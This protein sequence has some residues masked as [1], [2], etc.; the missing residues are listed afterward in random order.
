V[1]WDSKD[2][3]SGPIPLWHQVA[4]RLRAAI[5]RGEFREGDALPSEAVLNRRFG[6]SRT[7]ARAALDALENER[8]VIRQ[9]GR[10][11]IVLPPPADV[12]LNLLASF[13]E[14][15]RSR[16]L[17]PSYRTESIRQV[18]ASAEVAAGLAVDRDTWVTRIER[19]LCASGRPL[20]FSIAWLSPTVLNGVKPPTRDY[21]DSGS[22][23][24]WLER[25]CG[26]RIAAGTQ[27]I[28]AGA[29]DDRIAS[30]LAVP[31]AS[32]ILIARRSSQT[33]DNLK[34]EYVVNHYRAD[35]YRFCVELVRP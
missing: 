26:A 7:T 30:W 20:A 12:P 31:T 11:S 22:L 25:E 19:L 18:K 24:A 34:V 15:M 13:E 35:L 2:L 4:E 21:L 10:G 33:M 9:S 16:G 1:T 27:Y 28:E 14:D 6:I 32:P 29:A 5:A 8:L 17:E 3:E 23:Y